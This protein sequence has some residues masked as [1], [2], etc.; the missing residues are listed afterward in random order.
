M[1]EQRGGFFYGWVI[2][3][4]GVV[5][6]LIIFGVVDSFGVMFKPI[7]EQFHWDRGT[8]SVASMINWI[9]L[10]LSTLLFGA[11]SDRFGSR[12]IIIVGGLIFIAGTLLLS[13][14]QSLWQLYLY[15]G[16]LLAIG[17]SAA[18]VSLIAFVTKVFVRNQ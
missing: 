3:G 8:T 2:V 5:L 10:G 11:L 13:Q 16:I 14:I 9:S 6:S 7:S 17:R 12:R 1:E 15:F 18:G 4:A